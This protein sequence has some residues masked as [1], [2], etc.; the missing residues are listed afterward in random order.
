M[1]DIKKESTLLLVS[2]RNSIHLLSDSNSC[3]RMNPYY[4]PRLPEMRLITA[5]K[6]AAPTI[7]QITG[8]E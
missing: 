5:T 4:F 8:N 2:L 1:P 6:R 7:D 3:P